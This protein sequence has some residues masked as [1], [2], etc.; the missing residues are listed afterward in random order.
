MKDVLL[1]LKTHTFNDVLQYCHNR[2]GKTYQDCFLHQMDEE[3]YGR[4]NVPLD[5]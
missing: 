2:T 3:V 5:A 4:L 1:R